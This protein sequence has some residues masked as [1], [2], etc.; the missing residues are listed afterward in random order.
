MLARSKSIP[1]VFPWYSNMDNKSV[2]LDFIKMLSEL[3]ESNQLEA[4]KHALMSAQ[5]LNQTKWAA[6]RTK[7]GGSS[8]KTSL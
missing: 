1:K 2:H 6:A 3:D 7:R 5:K 8:S 4:S